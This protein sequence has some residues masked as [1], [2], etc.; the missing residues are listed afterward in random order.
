MRDEN[1]KKKRILKYLIGLG[2]GV[3][4]NYGSIAGFSEHE[5]VFV[6]N[7]YHLYEMGI[8]MSF[9]DLKAEGIDV[10]ELFKKLT[11]YAS[12]DPEDRDKEYEK[13]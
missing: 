12:L 5:C 11:E 8:T 6:I 10:D 9:K 7:D 2:I 3:T 4:T 13:I 1:Y